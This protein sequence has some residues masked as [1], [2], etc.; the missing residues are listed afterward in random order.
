MKIKKITALLAALSIIS[1]AMPAFG[2][3]AADTATN[4][5]ANAKE[6]STSA[7]TATEAATVQTAP[8]TDIVTTTAVKTTSAT[9]TVTT[10]TVQ[11]T[12]TAD[13]EKKIY[14][15]RD[16]WGEFD[17]K[18]GTLTLHGELPGHLSFYGLDSEKYVL[19]IVAADD[20]VLP[21]DCNQFFVRMKNCKKIDISKADASKVT[22][23][24]SMFTDTSVEE[25]IL[26]NLDTSNV[27]KCNCMFDH[28]FFL[29][30]VDLSGLDLSGVTNMSCMF[31][32][33]NSLEEVNF[34]K[35]D[36]SKL[37]DMSHMFKECYSLKKVDISGLDT[38]SVKD[39]SFMFA[40]S[41]SLKNVEFG[42]IDTSKLE[43]A[44]AMFQECWSLTSVDLSCFDLSDP[45]VFE[46]MFARCRSLRTI[47]T[48]E[49]TGDL[50][51]LLRI[52][53]ID[54]FNEK[55]PDVKVN[56]N[57]DHEYFSSAEI[58]NEGENTY[59]SNEP[60]KEVEFMEFS[61]YSKSLTIYKIEDKEQLQSYPNKDDVLS[62][63]VRGAL[64]YDCS[65]LFSSFKNCQKISIN[66]AHGN[67]TS[68]RAM[69]KDCEKLEKISFYNILNTSRTTDMSSMFENCYSLKELDLEYF[70]TSSV[71][72][73]DSMFK[74]TTSL[75]SL[76][77]GKN[78]KEIVEEM[79]LHNGVWTEGGYGNSIS[80]SGEFAV[81]SNEGEH[82]YIC[83]EMP[84]TVGDCNS[85]GRVNTADLVKLSS[86]ILGKENGSDIDPKNS[87]VNGDDAVDVFD[88]VALRKLII[89]KS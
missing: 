8:V 7:E 66:S 23:M 41:Y 67:P 71:T 1:S 31:A 55:E 20:A 57:A 9:E 68:T 33:C 64:P 17:E 38:S 80:G 63:S 22:N 72:S 14:R 50:S 65:E 25:V 53:N 48:G 30:K 78:F 34:G 2:V 11:N 32:M 46:F 89:N 6:Q 75:S 40:E 82:K 42:E 62:I 49:K 84:V 27:T 88:M 61:D 28:C 54:W 79:K 83:T 77:L 29:K 56:I 69:F 37:E 44:A 86:F 73:F 18:T 3:S 58:K 4:A 36:T 24:M 35:H 15:E 39:M 81:F 16:G 19:S 21:E 52:P 5:A 85:D 10:T 13:S 70:D 26:G 47:K 87:D 45:E 60:L 43:K 59:F 74:N 76:Q 12:D 51:Q